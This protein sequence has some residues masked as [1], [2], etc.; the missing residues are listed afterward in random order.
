MRVCLGGKWVKIK[1]SR[2]PPRASN[3]FYLPVDDN[4]VRILM[5]TQFI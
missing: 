2:W 4:W 3:M 5:G 1:N